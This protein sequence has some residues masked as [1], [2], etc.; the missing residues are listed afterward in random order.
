[1]IGRLLYKARQV[2]AFNPVVAYYRDVV[3]PKILLQP[4][5]SGTTDPSAEIHVMTSETDWM[6]TVWSLRSFY[7][8]APSRYRLVIHGDPTLSP[9]S[10]KELARQF[11][12]A[13]VL[14]GRAARAEVLDS[15]A[16]HPRCRQLREERVISM[17]AFDF[18]HFLSTDKMILFDSDLL[19]FAPPRVFL[20]YLEDQTRRVN[21][22]NPDVETS[23]SVTPDAME[24]IGVPLHPEVNSGFGLVHRECLS[25][26]RLEELLALPGVADGHPWRF[27]QTLYALRCTPY[28]VELL[29]E[30]YRVFLE[31]DVGDRPFRHYVGAVRD[32]MYAEGMRKLKGQL[33]SSSVR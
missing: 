9:Q 6:N 27:E 1:M 19:F 33:L 7:A 11:P 4:P 5:L 8:Q 26:D 3:R 28:G 15:L 31:G 2:A 22:F 21:V 30:D 17:K 25:L 24:K 16:D 20:D 12:D 23:Y 32:R 10:Q 18:P 29:P 14:D 13:R